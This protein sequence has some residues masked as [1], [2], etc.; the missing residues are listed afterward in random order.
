MSSKQ[1][2]YLRVALVAIALVG[3]VSALLPFI[4]SLKPSAKADAVYAQGQ[5]SAALLEN[6]RPGEIR[7]ID[8]GLGAFYAVSP[9]Q[10]IRDDLDRA[11]SLAASIE[12]GTFS[13]E[14]DAFLI[15]SIPPKKRGADCAVLHMEKNPAGSGIS[16][17]CSAGTVALS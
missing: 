10:D 14:V 9:S 15:W 6:L 1:S 2:K 3:I 11:A 4:G 7:F 17:S 8:T 12:Y 5:F 16:V 13:E